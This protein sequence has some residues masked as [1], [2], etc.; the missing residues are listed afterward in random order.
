MKNIR[1]IIHK[2]TW[3]PENTVPWTVTEDCIIACSGSVYAM[4][5]Y[6]VNTKI[7]KN[8]QLMNQVSLTYPQFGLY[9]EAFAFY[10]KQGDVI[11]IE[12]SYGDNNGY[13]NGSH[14]DKR[15]ATGSFVAIA[16]D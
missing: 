13:N 5:G 10:A 9:S 15:S 3:Y 6:S 8:N 14:N 12:I 4:N 11:T 1:E 7:F 16:I 2:Q